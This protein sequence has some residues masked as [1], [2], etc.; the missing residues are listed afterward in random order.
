MLVGIRDSVFI[1]WSRLIHGVTIVTVTFY[2]NIHKCSSPVSKFCRSRRFR[3]AT[4]DHYEL[5]ESDIVDAVEKFAATRDVLTIGLLPEDAMSLTRDFKNSEDT[6]MT[7][8]HFS[9][10]CSLR[11]YPECIVTRACKPKFLNKNAMILLPLD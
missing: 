9:R 11:P 8:I 5:N 2:C 10:T 4:L 6:A 7:S 3:A 1:K